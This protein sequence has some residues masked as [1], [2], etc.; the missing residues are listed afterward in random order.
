MVLFF[1]LMIRRPPR[2]TRT[3]TLFPYTTL[4][5]SP[6]YLP[7]RLH[8]AVRDVALAPAVPGAVDGDREAVVAVVDGA[9]HHVVEPGI[10]AALVQAE[11]L[12]AAA[13]PAGDLGDRLQREGADR[14]RSEEH[15]SELQSLMR[16]SY[17]VFC[18]KK[19]SS[20][21]TITQSSDTHSQ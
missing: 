19:K 8:E 9:C 16:I 2:T 17:A 10:V 3:D 20:N 15:T 5:R 11:H 18:L 14:R 13:I 1:F 12:H 21:I 7:P 6:R 4:F